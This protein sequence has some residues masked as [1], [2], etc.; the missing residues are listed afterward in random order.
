[1]DRVR[2]ESLSNDKK[3][4]NQLINK[5]IKSG[6]ST[7]SVFLLGTTKVPKRIVRSC[8]WFSSCLQE[9]KSVTRSCAKHGLGSGI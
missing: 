3:I 1:M 7:N 6:I 9:N 2:L 4:L 5:W 8:S